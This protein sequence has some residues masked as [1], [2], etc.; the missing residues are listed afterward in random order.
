MAKL[1]AKNQVAIEINF[2]EFMSKSGRERG[3]LIAYL[4]RNVMLA[5]KYGAPLIA[6]S[7]AMSMWELRDPLCLVSLGIQ[8]GLEI[9][10]AKFTVFGQPKLIIE[11]ARHRRSKKWIMPGVEIV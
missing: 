9:K 1:A 6:C 7:G 5:K 10:D 4:R 2:R 8:L 11:R 3:K